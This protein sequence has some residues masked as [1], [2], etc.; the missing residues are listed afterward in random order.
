[1]CANAGEDHE[2]LTAIEA[3]AIR[4]RGSD[5]RR[6]DG[7]LIFD[8][9][10]G[11]FILNDR[12]SASGAS[13]SDVVSYDYWGWFDEYHLLRL[14]LY[15]AHWYAVLHAATGR[16]T[17]IGGFPVQSPDSNWIVSVV[18]R[19]VPYHTNTILVWAKDVDGY[20]QHARST[21]RGPARGTPTT[22]W[23]SKDTI[24]VC[25][26][27]DDTLVPLGVLRLENGEWQ[28]NLVGDDVMSN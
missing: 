20:R 19:R 22:R 2:C 16:L 18:P 15:E 21:F 7:V 10:D 1:M 11:E 17:R 8:M 24:Q 27:S 6:D 28:K 13:P 23:V 14:Q 25:W 12:T 9:P 5:V 26:H 3:E 4:L